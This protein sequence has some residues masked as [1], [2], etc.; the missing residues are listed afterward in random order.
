MDYLSTHP[1]RARE[2]VSWKF[3]FADGVH[4]K[5][6]GHA[7]ATEN[8]RP[9]SSERTP[10]HLFGEFMAVGIDAGPHGDDEFRKVPLLDEI[11]A[12][13]ERPHLPRHAAG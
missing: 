1:D 6:A 5:V 11:E 13:S 8:P 3:S 9:D 4:E 7:H 2:K 10:R 12:R